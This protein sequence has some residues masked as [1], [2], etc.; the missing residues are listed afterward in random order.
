MKVLLYLLQKEFKQIVR[1][2]TILPIIFILPLVQLGVLPLVMD[3]EVKQVN[4]VVID[5]DH[6]PLSDKL[7]HKIGASGYFNFIAI[8]PSYKQAIEYL[9]KGDA[10]LVL[11]IPNSFETSLVKEKHAAVSVS[12]DAI[13]GTKSSLGTAYLISVIGDFNKNVQMYSNQKLITPQTIAVESSIWF[14]PYANYHWFIVPG[15]MAFLLTIF[16]GSI[17]ALNIVKEKEIGTIEQI[18][19]TPIRKWQFVLGKLIPFWIAGMLILTVSLLVARWF[20]GIRIVGS[21]SILYALTGVYLIALLGF[22]LFI[23]TISNNQLQSMF[24]SFFFLMIFVL[25]SG[26]FTSIESMPQ[27]A[28]Y[29]AHSLPITYFMKALRMVILKGSSLLQLKEIF[30]I[31]TGFA[32]ALNGLAVWNYKKTS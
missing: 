7:V 9:R 22:G 30:L 8:E 11:E 1:D 13:N 23:S 21:I 4:V 24:L 2:K 29:I 18:N 10:D 14:N 32:I 31:L 6:S 19:V 20:Y 3:F 15:I 16:A 5:K 12:V 28:R 27:W 17:S 25:M 26:L